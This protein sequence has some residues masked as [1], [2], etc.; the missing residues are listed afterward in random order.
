MTDKQLILVT[1]NDRF[2]ADD[3]FAMATL[4]ILLGSKIKKVIRTRDQ[5][6]IDS[7]DIVF[8][9]GNV[10]NSKKNRFDHHQKEGA[11]KRENGIPYASF[12]LVW[13][14]F[15]KQI[16]GSQKV[17]DEVDRR[18]VQPVDAGDNGFVISENKI[19]DVELYSLGRMCNVFGSTWKEKENYNESFKEVVKIAKKILEREI[20][21][22]KHQTEALP[23]IERS[24][25]KTFD[26]RVLVL[27]KYLP[28]KDFIKDKPEI[29][30]VVYPSINDNFFRINSV[31]DDSFVNRKDF[32]KEWAGLMNEDLEK[33]T[34]V[35]G[36][37]FCH[38]NL[39]LVVADTKQSA[40]ELAKL[41]LG[42]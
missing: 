27:D 36:S 1:H 13:K 14:K 12:G 38:R 30:F 10:Y 35:R 31:Q 25:K 18:I 26:K 39:F 17:A 9:V 21:S 28:F 15:G 24:Y 34:G 32:P 22:A 3:V 2:H 20:I 19:D 7:A 6:I 29:L 23:L 40:I 41:A 37:K 8:D 33:V 5:K 11:G 4:Q 42:K 16:C